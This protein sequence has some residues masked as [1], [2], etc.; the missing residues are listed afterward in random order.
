MTNK[1]VHVLMEREDMTEREVLDWIAEVM[2]SYEDYDDYFD[3][4]EVLLTEFGLEPDYLFD[5]M[6]LGD[7]T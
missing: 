4:E 5:L 7:L 1:L 3:L 2:G 6:E